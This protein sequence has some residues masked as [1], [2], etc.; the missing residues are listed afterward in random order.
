MQKG[1]GKNPLRNGIPNLSTV[2]RCVYKTQKR[3][4]MQGSGANALTLMNQ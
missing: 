1:G 4:K 3:K 2:A